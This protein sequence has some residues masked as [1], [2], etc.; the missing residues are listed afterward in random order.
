[1]SSLLA[2]CLVCLFRSRRGFSIKL[3]LF[4]LQ[5]KTPCSGFNYWWGLGLGWGLR[6][7]LRLVFQPAYLYFYS[8]MTLWFFLQH[9][10][11]QYLLFSVI[12]V[13]WA[14]KSNYWKISSMKRNPSIVTIISLKRQIKLS[15]SKVAS[16]QHAPSS[17][18]KPW[19]ANL[20]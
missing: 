18:H 5:L 4:H 17:S 2:D 12:R 14:F 19:N 20:N 7:G 3:R 1:M 16:G 6:L 15:I 11:Q 10:L 13:N 9:L 8:S